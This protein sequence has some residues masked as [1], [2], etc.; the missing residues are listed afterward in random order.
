MR[1]GIW[2]LYFLTVCYGSIF[3]GKVSDSGA[4]H[5]GETQH[6][7]YIGNLYITETVGVWKTF[8]YRPP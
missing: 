6:L 3:A 7:T 4:L 1:V 2:T 5:E 8:L